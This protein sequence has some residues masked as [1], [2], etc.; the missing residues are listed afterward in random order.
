MIVFIL[1]N[2]PSNIAKLMRQKGANCATNRLINGSS[3][4]PTLTRR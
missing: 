2:Y 1:R 3:T 4:N